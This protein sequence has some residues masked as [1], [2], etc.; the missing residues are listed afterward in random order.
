[1]FLAR[2]S[3]GHLITRGRLIPPG[4]L[5][6]ACAC[7]TGLVLPAAALEGQ[8]NAA[9]PP[10]KLQGD[11][12]QT[13]AA[14][15]PS[16]TAAEEQEALG[17]ARSQHPQLLPLLERL[18]QDDPNEYRKALSDLYRAQQKLHRMADQNPERYSLALALWNV[19]SRIHLLAARMVREA[20]GSHD[21]TLKALLTERRRLRVE[22][23][24]FDRM[25]AAERVANLDVQLNQMQQDP[26][27]DIE[28]ELSKLKQTAAHQARAAK[29]NLENAKARRAP[30]P[31]QEPR[32]KAKDKSE[33]GTKSD[34]VS[35]AR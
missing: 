7:L 8:P 20:D 26:D 4:R 2:S 9:D 16:L 30:K 21:D 18:R 19:Q 35:E 12:G 29:M 27:G 15:A 22:L 5:I 23:L 11:A 33:T 13:K 25:K 17:F 10:A 24:Q 6:L 14:G 32:P 1:M 3:L 31:K 28:K 34:A